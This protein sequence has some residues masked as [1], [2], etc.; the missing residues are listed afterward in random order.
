MSDSKPYISNIELVIREVP[1][2]SILGSLLSIIH[3]IDLSNYISEEAT[4]FA[5]NISVVFNNPPEN[6][7]E[8]LEKLMSEL[9]N[10]FDSNTLQNELRKNKIF[11]I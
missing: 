5:D 4:Q 3:V 7:L 2:R 1:Q 11:N 10:W 9:E 6:F 8:E